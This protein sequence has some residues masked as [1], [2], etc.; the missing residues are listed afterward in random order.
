MVGIEG[1]LERSG[2]PTNPLPFLDGEP[3]LGRG[4]VV[5]RPDHKHVAARAELFAHPVRPVLRPRRNLDI[6]QRVD[7]I[8][9]QEL[10]K[11]QHLRLVDRIIV[12]V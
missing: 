3:T 10:A 12:S 1:V 4:P 6:D 9:T 8:G 5:G 2:L 11:L 7:P